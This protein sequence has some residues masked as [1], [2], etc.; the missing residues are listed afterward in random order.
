MSL[1]QN[2]P[3]TGYKF[4]RMRL[5]ISHQVPAIPY[6][7]ND[8]NLNYML[9]KDDNENCLLSK[10]VLKYIAFNSLYWNNEI[11]KRKTSCQ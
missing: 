8:S 11:Y 10:N 2:L 5:Y 4:Y 1:L 7:N 9:K 3:S 6:S